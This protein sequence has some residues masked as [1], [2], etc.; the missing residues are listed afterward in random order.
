MSDDAQARIRTL[1]EGLCSDECAGRAPGTPGGRAARKLLVEAFADARVEVAERP[2]PFA[3]GANLVGLLPG[4]IDRWILVSAHYDHLG[5]EGKHV[6]RGADDNAAAVAIVVEVARAL[7][8]AKRAGRGVI[9][10]AFD[11]EEPPHFLTAGMGSEHW[12][13][14]P[15]VPLEKIDLMIGMDLVGHS[16]GDERFPKE[17]RETVFALGAEKS[18]GTSALLDGMAESEPGVRLRRVDAATVPP[19]SDYDAFWKRKIPFLFLTNGRWRHYHTPQDTPEKLD[20]P[21]IAATARWLTRF[22]VACCERPGRKIAFTAQSDDA[23]TLRTLLTITETL[24]ALSPEA[25]QAS[26]A[27]KK[28]LLECDATGALREDRR[29]MVSMIVQGLE[30]RLA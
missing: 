23:S 20:Y 9:L 1:V 10:V 8:V 7:S 15:D 14:H 30:E 22:V 24:A 6:Y 5:Q 19:L 13:V 3:R 2:V 21:K 11:S 27:A 18:E 25:A 26:Q 29:M 17:V 12:A 28:L 4:T 16:L